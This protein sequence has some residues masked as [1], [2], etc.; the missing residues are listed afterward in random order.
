MQLNKL[1]FHRLTDKQTLSTAQIRSEVDRS[2]QV[3]ATQDGSGHIKTEDMS[4][5]ARKV[6][7][8]QDTLGLVRTSLERS[9]KVRTGQER[10]AQVSHNHNKKNITLYE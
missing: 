7:T 3:I 1:A 8:G 10:S 6:R 9:R 5:K 2:R 4:R